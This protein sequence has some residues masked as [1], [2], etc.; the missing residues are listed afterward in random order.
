MIRGVDRQRNLGAGFG[1]QRLVVADQVGH[2][3]RQAFR[4]Q[5]NLDHREDLTADDAE[6]G[7]PADEV[8][9]GEHF[10]H[11][12]KVGFARRGRPELA[13][14]ERGGKIGG[15]ILAP[16]EADIGAAHAGQIIAHAGVRADLGDQFL[17]V[18]Q[19][20]RGEAGGGIIS[21]GTIDRLERRG[22]RRGFGFEVAGIMV[23]AA[24]FERE[25]QAKAE[26]E[27]GIDFGIIGLGAIDQAP[28]DGLFD[29]LFPFVGAPQCEAGDQDMVG[30]RGVDRDVGRILGGGDLGR[31]RRGIDAVIV[32]HEHHLLELGLA[33]VDH[34]L[35]QLIVGKR[36]EAGSFLRP[37]LGVHPGALGRRG[38]HRA[39]L[40]DMLGEVGL[41][42][43]RLGLG[44]GQRGG[45]GV[46]IR[47]KMGIARIGKRRDPLA[48]GRGYEAGNIDPP[49]RGP[50]GACPGPDAVAEE[51]AD[52]Q[53]LL[54][55][56]HR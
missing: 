20:V 14:G 11:F 3:E 15:E 45:A 10:G 18:E 22:Q 55:L 39:Q 43:C 21:G 40:G 37:D 25:A 7:E 5:R 4:R 36:G 33:V 23:G 52:D 35:G 32:G 2:L 48:R 1:E 29:P 9:I 49:E 19:L 54:D 44:L 6:I 12:G 47:D 26:R 16:P 38:E 13:M 56:V 53:A 41:Q 17:A 50:P 8:E 31:R 30:Q 46:G 24:Q 34:L 27:L 51:L 42:C 28:F